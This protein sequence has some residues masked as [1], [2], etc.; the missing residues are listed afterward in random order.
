[1]NITTIELPIYYLDIVVIIESD[2][3]QVSKKFKLGITEV[4]LQANAWTIHDEAGDENEIFL[5]LK[6]SALD[7]W[8]ITHELMHI[9][10][11]ICICRAITMDAQNDEPLAYLQGYIGQ[12][13]FEFRDKFI[14][15]HL[16]VQNKEVHL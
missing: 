3:L 7:Y 8:T 13:L 1:M 5:L 6:P 12:K 2:W 9:I 11:K 16:E 4:D 14:Q 15:K 10:T